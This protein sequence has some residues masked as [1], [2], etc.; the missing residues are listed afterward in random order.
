MRDPERPSAAHH[1]PRDRL[2]GRVREVDFASTRPGPSCWLAQPSGPKLPAV[3]CALRHQPSSESKKE[4]AGHLQGY[5]SALKTAVILSTYNSPRRL[6]LTIA[7]YSIQS[8]KHFNIIVA[9]DGSNDETRRCIE[10]LRRRFGLSI[11]HVWQEDQGFRKCRI[12][13]RCVLA[14][15]ADYL[16]FSDGD[17]IPRPDF[18]ATHLHH[19]R[20]DVFLSGGCFRLSAAI[21]D[22]L[23]EED[24]LA[25]RATDPR[26]LKRAGM[27]FGFK[28]L[29]LLGPG[30]AGRFFDRFLLTSL[31]WNGNNSSTWRQAILRVNGFDERMGYYAEDREMGERLINVGVL[32]R[33]VRCSAV[34][35]HLEHGREYR[36]PETRAY[37]RKLLAAT[38]RQ[39][40]TRTEYGIEQPARSEDDRPAATDQRIVSR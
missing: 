39:K 4:T 28:R 24:V 19:A 22:R 35:A 6:A 25:G 7:G 12:L 5:G 23:T 34:L 37:N 30:F 15:E 20:P 17:C 8:E 16:V 9:D 26:W 38:K 11:E 29:K 1:H 13:N 36:N 14:T 32:P 3:R 21:S 2:D 40:L 10:D 31:T 18:L 27:K 33:R